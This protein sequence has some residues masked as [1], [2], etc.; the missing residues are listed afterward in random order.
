MNNKKFSQSIC[1]EK[2]ET[3]PKQHIDSIFH[4]WN[5]A[6][7]K[8]IVYKTTLDFEGYL[9]KCEKPIHFLGLQRNSIVAWLCVFTRNN[10]RWFALLVDPDFQRHGL[11]ETLLSQA[12]SE[13]P[14]LCGWIVEHDN[15]LKVDGTPYF[16]P[17][18]F[19]LKNGFT[20]T[21]ETL[22]TD[23]LTTTKIVWEVDHSLRSR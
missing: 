3:L 11:G 2:T 9:A 5:R 15:Y 16:S 13:E 23:L 6:Y 18:A 19:Y 17:K 20:V 1:F 10:E 22:V 4:I 12:K 21:E 7:P 14:R 8:Q